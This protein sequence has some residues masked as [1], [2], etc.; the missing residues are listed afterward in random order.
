MTHWIHDRIGYDCKKY[1]FV[2]VDFWPQNIFECFKNAT[3]LIVF[4]AI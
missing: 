3:I 4:Q 1:C 2:V